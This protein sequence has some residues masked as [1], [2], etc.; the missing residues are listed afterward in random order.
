M[1]YDLA[2]WNFKAPR[3]SQFRSSSR[4]SKCW[5]SNRDPAGALAVWRPQRK[6]IW[7]HP[8]VKNHLRLHDKPHHVMIWALRQHLQANR[9]SLLPAS[10]EPIHNKNQ[11]SSNAVWELHSLSVW[12]KSG[13]SKC[14]CRFMKRGWRK[15]L[16]SKK[17]KTQT[18]SRKRHNILA[19]INNQW[20]SPLQHESTCSTVGLELEIWP[21]YT[22]STSTSL[23]SVSDILLE[24][25]LKKGKSDSFLVFSP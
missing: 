22:N 6:T 13:L 21:P 23:F 18:V 1:Q 9:N 16:Q 14:S 11:Q 2:V 7:L 24:H 25:F 19:A 15:T 8:S 3:F 12:R 4:Q 10:A 17:K 5:M 20:K